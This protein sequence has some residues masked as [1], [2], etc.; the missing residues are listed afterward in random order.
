MLEA[1]GKQTL[2]GQVTRALA[3]QIS[4]GHYKPGEK[5]P[6]EQQLIEEF[7]V[8][9]TVIREAVA[10]LRAAGVVN[11]RQ[12]VG[13][14]VLN[15]QANTNF[16]IDESQLG[17][18][19]EISAVLELRIALESE[20]AALAATRRTEAD[21]KSINASL[22]DM[23]AAIAAN[24]NAL[25]ADLRFHRAIA[26]STGNVHFV[27]LFGYLGELVIPRARMETFKFVGLSHS[28]YL[29]RVHQEHMQIAAAVVRGDAEAARAAMRLHLADSRERLRRYVV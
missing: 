21:I 17:M 11:T 15:R 3:E 24:E 6:T 22:D 19:E 16:Q 2:T 8:S 4:S 18:V 23:K 13:A 12:G 1:N 9:R 5:L 29:E 25:E 28:E 27:N 7:N 26:T 20:A 14:F 10:S